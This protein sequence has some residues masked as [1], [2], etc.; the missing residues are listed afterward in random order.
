MKKLNGMKKSLSSLENKKM[1]GMDLN[2][3]QGGRRASIVYS[4]FLYSD[5][6]RDVDFYDQDGN[7]VERYSEGC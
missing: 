2:T 4:N 1:E 5:G 3:V 6:S 7:W